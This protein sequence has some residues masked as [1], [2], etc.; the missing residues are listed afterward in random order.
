[1]LRTKYLSCNPKCQTG[2]ISLTL[3]KVSAQTKVP[4]PK[5]HDV[6][7]C[8]VLSIFSIN[9]VVNSITKFFII[10]HNILFKRCRFKLRDLNLM[11]LATMDS[12]LKHGN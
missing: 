8:V 7:N 6:S 5:N 2:N 9:Y 4:N 1:M 11:T 12:D 10:K 3:M